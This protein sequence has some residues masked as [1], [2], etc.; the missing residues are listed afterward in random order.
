MR[1]TDSYEKKIIMY[2]FW[3]DYV[4][5][6]YGEKANLSHTDISLST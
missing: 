5:A 4:N 6:K 2:E 1:K 3:H